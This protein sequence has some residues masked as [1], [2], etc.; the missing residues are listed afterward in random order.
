MSSGPGDRL[1]SMPEP[2][3][4]LRGRG[5][6]ESPRWHDGR[7]WFADWSAREIL[8]LEAGGEAAV[9]LGAAAVPHCF[10]FLPDG[11]LLVVSATRPGRLLRREPDG[12]LVAH[13]DLA[14][15]SP[16]FLND[17]VVSD[18]GDAYVNDVAFDL[19]A[20]APAAPGA[21]VHVTPG[22]RA[23]RV[24]DDLG[25]PNGM[26]ITADGSTLI[27]AESYA[28][29]LTAFT[30]ADDG[31]LAGRR[32]WAELGGDAPDGIGVDSDGA[33]WYAD[34]PH[35]HCRRVTEG[36]EVLATVD[37]EVGCFACTLGGPDGRTL[38]IVGAEWHGAA[39]ALDR[40]PTGLVATVPAPASRAGHP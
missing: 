17:I 19:L 15:V 36:G 5:L 10:D 40:P 27:V 28:S 6:L 4:L 30:I 9:A 34:V 20:G 31:S 8:T 37:L 21:I 18:R 29:R 26:A 14:G 23:H 16:G 3:I 39:G 13:A 2:E 1:P 22:G 12:T 11:R 24:A 7:L 32:V 25:F 33:V 38:Y 35:R